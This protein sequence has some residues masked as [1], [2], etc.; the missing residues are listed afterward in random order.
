LGRAETQLRRAPTRCGRSPV[1]R[2][3]R[4]NHPGPFVTRRSVT[5]PSQDRQLAGAAVRATSRVC[6]PHTMPS[7]KWLSIQEIAPLFHRPIVDV[8]CALL[9]IE[10]RATGI[11]FGLS[12]PWAN[13]TLCL[14]CS[15]AWRLHDGAQEGM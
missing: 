5:V 12:P 2:G 4:S 13:P 6:A 11:C 10:N 14:A 3:M 7:K 9:P 15:D 1:M 8:A